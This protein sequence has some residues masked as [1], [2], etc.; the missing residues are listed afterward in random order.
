M[1]RLIVSGLALL[2][3]PGLARAQSAEVS[4]QQATNLILNAEKRLPDAEGWAIDLL[5]VLRVNEL[6]ASKE[7]VCAAIAVIDQESGFRADPAVP[8]LGRIAETALRAKLDGVPLLGSAALAFLSSHPTSGN[9]YLSRIRAAR[10][11]RDL[12][13]TYRAM[14]EDAGRT[15]SLGSVI[16]AGFFNSTVENHNDIATIGSMQVAVEF[17]LAVAERRRWLP[18]SLGDV[19]AVRDE[20]YTRRGGMYYGVLQLL[21]YDSGYNRKIFRFADYNAGRYSSRNAAL[22]Q[23]IAALSGIKLSTD[24]DLLVYAKGGGVKKTVGNSEMAI[25]RVARAMLPGLTDAQI[26]ADLLLEK[27][28]GFVRTQT[29]LGLRDAYQHKTGK[30]PDF[31]IIPSIDLHSP[32]IRHMMTT[33]IF[34]ETVNKRYQSCLAKS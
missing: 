32:K 11:E 17:A 15:T 4:Q 2:L 27:E 12:D 21:G 33:R 30:V 18:M 22:Q 14:V 29:Y 10:T 24:G 5:D 1:F 7:N 34:A 20:L 31:A 9:S 16:N 26:R 6:P 25:R 23:Q 3:A 28:M 19:Y 8:G 13:M